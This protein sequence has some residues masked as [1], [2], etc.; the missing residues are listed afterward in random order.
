M[1]ERK[2]SE[3]PER[4]RRRIARA[5]DAALAEIRGHDPALAHLLQT[6]IKTGQFFSYSPRRESEVKWY[7]GLPLDRARGL[8]RR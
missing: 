8:R 5:I 2:A 4:D 1:R 7:V 6:A 3:T